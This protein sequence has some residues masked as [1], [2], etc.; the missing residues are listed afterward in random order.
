MNLSR[1][2]LFGFFGAAAATPVLGL[3]KAHQA[4]AEPIT[5]EQW[6]A[7][8]RATRPIRVPDPP[9]FP[10]PAIKAKG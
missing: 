9:R 10:R 3:Q 1:R 2:N 7:F 5:K 4:S 8:E 6:A